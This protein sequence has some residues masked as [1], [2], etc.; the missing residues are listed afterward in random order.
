MSSSHFGAENARIERMESA[1]RPRGASQ[2]RVLHILMELRPSGAEVM[3]RVAAPFWFAGGNSHSILATGSAEGSYA[4]HLRAAGFEVFHIP[5][6]KT[7]KFFYEVFTLIRR[8]RFDAVHIHTEQAN[9]CYGMVARLA[10]VNRI[11]H[12]IHNVFPFTGLLR[13]VRIAM[14]R[15]L[16]LLGATPVSVGRSVA[17]NEAQ[18]LWNRT[19]VI[20]NWYDASV[21]RPPSLEER[22]AARQSYGIADDRLVMATLGNCNEWKNHSLLFQA[23]KL[24][25]TSKKNWCYLHAGSEDEAR[26]ERLLASELGVAEHCFFLGS[27]DD[28]RSVLW[29]ADLFVMPSRREGFSI[30]AIEAAAS[31]LPLILSDVPGLRDLKATMSDGLWVRPEPVALADAIESASVRFP[32]GSAANASSA[33]KVFGVE[34]GAKAYDDLYAGG[35]PWRS[36]RAANLPES[37]AG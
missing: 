27:I 23:L 37:S 3:L 9:V 21:F 25:L 8:G 20:P 10:G 24:L 22:V 13:L 19:I 33:R 17:D 5:F 12:T 16:R 15:G 31:G 4:N 11:V 36:V 14:R 28:P 35:R 32:S 2:L 29:A 18:H 6:R 1:N 30:A 26:S 34:T 7:I